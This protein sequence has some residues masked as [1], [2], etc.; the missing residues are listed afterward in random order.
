[1]SRT[2]VFTLL[3]VLVS[4]QASAADTPA[5]RKRAQRAELAE[6]EARHTERSAIEERK[7]LMNAGE[8]SA[9]AGD[10]ADPL[11]VAEAYLLEAQSSPSKL[12]SAWAHVSGVLTQ[13]PSNVRALLLAGQIGM[14]RGQPSQ[15]QV[16]YQAATVADP[17]SA[18]AFL[19]LGQSWSRLGNEEQAGKA[20]GEYRRLRGLAPLQ[21]AANSK[22]V[23]IVPGQEP[24]R[25]LNRNLETTPA[26]R[27]NRK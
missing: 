24:P 11:K 27:K 10:G 26:T 18:S 19:G 1:M 14:L 20:Y 23:V 17:S 6:L 9:G 16:H 25:I 12:D 8:S 5:E 3:A 22:P 2:P 4:L 15:A 21:T 7:L 13:N